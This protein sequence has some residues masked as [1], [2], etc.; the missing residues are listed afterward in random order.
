MLLR[1]AWGPMVWYIG[2]SPLEE[3]R[4][5]FPICRPYLE[6]FHWIGRLAGIIRPVGAGVQY[7]GAI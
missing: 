2:S 5:I 7:L 3:G 6:R 1:R 4:V